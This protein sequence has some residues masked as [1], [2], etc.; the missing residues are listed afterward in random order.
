M[1][2]IQDL[3]KQQKKDL[4]GKSENIRIESRGFI[5]PPR[6]AALLTSSPNKLGDIIGNQL[7]GAL[8]GSANRPSDT[9][10]KGTAFFRKPISLPAVTTALLRDSIEEGRKYFVKDA[11]S[12]NSIIGTIKQGASSPAGVATNIAQ[13]T[14][15]KVG[16]PAAIK[17]L[18]KELK[19]KLPAKGYGELFSRT[20][21]G[22]KPLQSSNK[23]SDY[24]EVTTTSLP[25]YPAPAVELITGDIKKSLKLRSPDEKAGW[26]GGNTHINE[27]EKYD[28]LNKLKAD[29]KKYRVANQAWVL[30]KK[31]GNSSVIP[32][33]GSVTGL[34]ED[35][36]PEWTNFRYIG[37]PFKVNRYLGVERSLKFNLKLYY[38]TVKEKEVMI[39]KIN[40]LKSLAFPYE[41]ISQM[42]YGGNP[43]NNDGTISARGNSQTPER[44]SQYA[45]SPNLVYLTIGD[46]Y[47]DVYGFIESLSFSV[48]DNT[49]WPNADA[50][51]GQDGRDPLQTI[52][53]VKNDTTLYPSVIDVS[54]GMKIIEN[55]KTETKNGIT[56]YK[57]NFDGISYESNGTTPNKQYDN[58]R[59]I[60]APFVINETKE[61]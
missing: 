24:K 52:F 6:V 41:E 42:T 31:Q 26:D 8:G 57:Y 46:M 43:F 49:V 23:F 12:P 32:F 1:A 36:Q 54:I 20:E 38:T 14:L 61:K 30:F 47:K 58:N 59:D 28:D 2:T 7:G 40:Y 45:F 48:E 29:I 34:S 4:Y 11:P 44:T 60:K 19:N 17:R 50:N 9:I 21:L 27:K 56:R 22:G 13:Q 37:S 16:S 10:F 39:K 5:N 33:V 53:G 55:H 18:A 15:N 51:G 3:F 25:K 35:I